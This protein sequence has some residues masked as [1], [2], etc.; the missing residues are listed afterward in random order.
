M[1]LDYRRNK[2]PLFVH[3]R[4]ARGKKLKFIAL[5]VERRRPAF[6]FLRPKRSVLV[7]AVVTT[8]RAL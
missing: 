2:G 5:G 7:R 1:T 8:S 3:I 4:R 6:H